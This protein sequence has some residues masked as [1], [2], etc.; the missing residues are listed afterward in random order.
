MQAH[1][2]TVFRKMFQIETLE[3]ETGIVRIDDASLP[4]LRAV[5]RFC[6]CAE[7]DFTHEVAAEDVLPV[8]HKYAID[9]LQKVCEEE[10]C[11]TING[12]NLPRR[13]K[14]AKKFQA[15]ELQ[16]RALRYLKRNFDEAIGGVVR[17]LF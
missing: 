11:A 14:L 4:V 8:A 13:L 12:R 15:K 7:I 16:A 17:E 6:Y 5:I 2:S 3:E 1:R 10:L 9:L